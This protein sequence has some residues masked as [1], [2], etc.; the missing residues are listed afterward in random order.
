MWFKF[1]GERFKSE[2]ERKNI[3]Q[4]FLA[5]MADT[6]ERY[7]RDLEKGHKTNLSAEL[8]SRFSAILNISMED[9]MS[10]TEGE[11]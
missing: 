4:R 1:N 9:L 6:S 10:K 11:S 7:I 2:R 5:E 8:L 3:S